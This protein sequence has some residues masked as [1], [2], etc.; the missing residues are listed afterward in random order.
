MLPKTIGVREELEVAAH[1]TRLAQCNDVQVLKYAPC[2][3]I[4]QVAE[5]T[6]VGCVHGG[7]ED[8]EEDS[9]GGGNRY[10]GLLGGLSN[11]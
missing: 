11:V 8:G 10:V 7:S 4:G 5:V 1:S 3:F 2:T 6:G 9:R